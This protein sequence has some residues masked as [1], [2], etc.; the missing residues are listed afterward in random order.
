MDGLASWKPLFFIGFLIVS[1]V[2]VGNYVRYSLLLVNNKVKYEDLKQKIIEITG[3]TLCFCLP[4]IVIYAYI[5]YSVYEETSA[6]ELLSDLKDVY[7]E[8]QGKQ[9]ESNFSKTMA[10]SFPIAFEK[11]IMFFSVIFEFV[12]GLFYAIYM[13]PTLSLL[14]TNHP[15]KETVMFINVL[16]GW[17]IIGWVILLMWANPVPIQMNNSETTDDQTHSQTQFQSVRNKSAK[18]SN[19]QKEKF[20]SLTDSLVQYKALLDEGAL[21]QEEF[22]SIKKDILN[23]L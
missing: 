3:L 8:L 9:P 21:T 18:K 17:T 5:N 2:Y 19:A 23:K 7:N 22:E 11:W 6:S 1:L 10:I 12:S 15:Q 16:F 20:D 14:K 4:I 13:K